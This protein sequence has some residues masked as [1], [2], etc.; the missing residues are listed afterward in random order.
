MSCNYHKFNLA[1]ISLV[2]DYNGILEKVNDHI[3]KLL[4]SIPMAVLW[5]HSH[6]CAERRNCSRSSSTF[7]MVKRYIEICSLLP[8]KD[9]S[10]ISEV[11]ITDHESDE[12]HV[13]FQKL[14]DL[15]FMTLALKSVRTTLSDA[16]MMFNCVRAIPCIGAETWM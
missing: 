16:P 11:L 5:K 1:V 6:L 4:Y 9:H 7:A 15:D 12:I 2:L 8:N 14:Q 13:F 10:E 3:N